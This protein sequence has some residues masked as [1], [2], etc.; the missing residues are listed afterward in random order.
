[1]RNLDSR[2][3]TRAEIRDQRPESKSTILVRITHNSN[4]NKYEIN[5]GIVVLTT[6]A[7]LHYYGDPR[8]QIHWTAVFTASS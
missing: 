5:P 7:Q 3:L 4:R 6:Q 1:M 8:L 2:A